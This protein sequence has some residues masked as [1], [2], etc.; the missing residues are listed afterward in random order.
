MTTSKQNELDKLYKL[1]HTLNR[2]QIK[3]LKKYLVGFSTRNE[4]ETKMLELANLLLSKKQSAPDIDFC[5][6]SIYG[7]PRDSRIDKLKT[8]LYNKVLDSLAIDINIQR[9]EYEDEIHPITI[10]LKKKATILQ[11]IRFTP[12]RESLGI[13]LLNDIIYTSRKYEMYFVLLEH[14]HQLK[15]MKTWREGQKTFEKFIEEINYYEKCNQANIRATDNYYKTIFHTSFSGNVGDKKLTSFYLDCIT[16]TRY[17]YQQTQSPSVGYYLLMFEMGY[18]QSIH[19]YHKAKE[20]CESLINL[21]QNN[22]SVYRKNRMGYAY[23]NLAECEVYLGHYEQ[24]IIDVRKSVGYLTP[25]S[26]DYYLNKQFEFEILFLNN[27]WHE[28]QLII[29]TLQKTNRLKQGDFRI[30]KYA[31]YEA[32]VHFKLGRFKECSR[33]LSLKFELSKDK[34]GWEIAIRILRIMTMIEL[35]RHDEAQPMVGNLQKHIERNA[36]KA[37]VNERDRM[38]LKLFRELDKAGFR[39]DN[40][41]K[42]PRDLHA[43][44]SEKNQPWSWKPLSPELIPVH[45]WL[46]SKL[47]AQTT[48]R[49][50]S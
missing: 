30:A 3:V 26:S 14:L 19:D 12:L 23:G 7:A 39:F 15:Y 27:K 41:S 2:Q 38:I 20:T 25:N 42:V 21:I 40:L 22:I 29:E 16:Q 11:I 45:E 34:L 24:A 33:Q 6:K 36:R 5:S 46:Q 35:N 47:P 8:R 50:K 9:D 10:R 1:L 49:R 37:D 17:D 43:R 18:Y 32:C 31:F 4:A 44:L 48:S 13:E 28:A